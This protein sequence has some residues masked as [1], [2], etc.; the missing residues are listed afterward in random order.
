MFARTIRTFSTTARVLAEQPKDKAAA[1][2]F[3]NIKRTRQLPSLD[4]PST[5]GAD[6]LGVGPTVR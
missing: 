6:I 3:S 4:I 1:L 5:G 2:G